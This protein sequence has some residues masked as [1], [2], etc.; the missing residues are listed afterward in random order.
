VTTPHP[1]STLLPYTT[2]FRSLDARPAAES[3]HGVAKEPE[4]RKYF[5]KDI[6]A[7]AQESAE[8]NNEEPIALRAAPQEVQNRQ[9]LQKKAPRWKKMSQLRHGRPVKGT[10]SLAF[11]RRSNG[12]SPRFMRV[13][14]WLPRRPCDSAYGK[15][16]TGR[17]RRRRG[18]PAAARHVASCYDGLA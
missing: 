18:S 3:L 1:V 12:T 14:A 15:R 8:E 11:P 6:H 13:T 5:H 9:N 10:A 17:S 16:S 7:G 2:L 4:V